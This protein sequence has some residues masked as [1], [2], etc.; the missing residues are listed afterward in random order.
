MSTIINT[1]SPFYR[2]INNAS[3]ASVKLE[4]YIFQ[5]TYSSSLVTANRKYTLK[6]DAIGSNTY[7]TFELSKLIRDYMITEYNDYATDS[8]WIQAVINIYNSSGTSI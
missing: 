8:L 7:V 6:K 3:L 1:R 4:L 2:K 5:G